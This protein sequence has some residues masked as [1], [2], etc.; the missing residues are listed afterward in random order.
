MKGVW[1]L[2]PIALIIAAAIYGTMHVGNLP[3]RVA[4]HFNARGEPDNWMN[5]SAAIWLAPGFALLFY[6][7]ISIAQIYLPRI[8]SIFVW[9]TLMVFLMANVQVATVLYGE[10]QITSALL[11]I[12]PALVLLVGFGI[13]Q[14]V[15]AIMT[16]KG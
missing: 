10:G 9:K 8:P 1:E 14:I 15:F 3:E 16:G 11:G 4:I 12:S 6:I 5:R 13:W 2:I 7:A